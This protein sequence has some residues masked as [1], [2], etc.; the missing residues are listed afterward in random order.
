MPIG[1][2]LTFPLS[3]FIFYMQNK[4]ERK[5]IKSYFIKKISALRG[6]LSNVTPL[7]FF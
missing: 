7:N 5:S 2:L 3:D 1:H 4:R 6:L